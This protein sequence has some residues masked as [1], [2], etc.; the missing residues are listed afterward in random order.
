MVKI[1]CDRRVTELRQ[2]VS[3][4]FNEIIQ[5]RLAVNHDNARNG[6]AAFRRAHIKR[7]VTAVDFCVLP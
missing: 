6:R 7:H 1:R 5:P 4:I 2:H 3:R